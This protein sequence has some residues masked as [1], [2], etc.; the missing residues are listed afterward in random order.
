MIVPQNSAPC[1]SDAEDEVP[2]FHFRTKSKSDSAGSTIPALTVT[3]VATVSSESASR[4]IDADQ[5][6]CRIPIETK[7]QIVNNKV[8]N[9]TLSDFTTCPS[10]QGH[11][12]N[13]TIGRKDPHRQPDG[14]PVVRAKPVV[15]EPYIE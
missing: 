5:P 3:S 14:C 11:G 12:N 6:A 9:A 4:Q 7:P 8:G 2:I 1:A 10:D 15:T 13:A